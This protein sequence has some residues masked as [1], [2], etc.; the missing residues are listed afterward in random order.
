MEDGS[1]SIVVWRYKEE[2]ARV[3]MATRSAIKAET[4]K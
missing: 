1:H 3:H 2:W 4:I